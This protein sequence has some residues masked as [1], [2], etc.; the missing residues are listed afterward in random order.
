[1]ASTVSLGSLSGVRQGV[2][3]GRGHGCSCWPCFAPGSVPDASVRVYPVGL[4]VGS[5]KEN[6]VDAHR[7]CLAAFGGVFVVLDRET[8]R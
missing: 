6:S 7:T 4:C 1:M 8:L 2:S 5:G 3:V